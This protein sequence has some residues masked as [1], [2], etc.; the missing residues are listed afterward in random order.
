MHCSE[1]AVLDKG[2]GATKQSGSVENTRNVEISTTFEYARV[3]AMHRS[4]ELH[5]QVWCVV[6]LWF[7]IL[8]LGGCGSTQPEAATPSTQPESA[9]PVRTGGDETPT[10]G[11][12][13]A[14][15][16]LTADYEP[17]F[18]PTECPFDVPS[19]GS[20]AC[21]FLVVPEDRSRADSPDVRLAVAVIQ[22]MA[23]DPEP[24][25]I[26]FLE[27]GPGGRALS[28]FQPWLDSGL[29]QNR[30]LVLFDQRGTG[31]SQPDLNC[32][33]ANWYG[34]ADEG[35]AGGAPDSYVDAM[36]ACRD[37]LV[38]EGVDLAAYTSA[39]SAADTHDLIRVLDYDEV[40]LLGISYGTRLALTMMRDFPQHIRSVVLDS[41]YPPNVNDYVE[42]AAIANRALEQLFDACAAD[43]ACDT[44]YPNLETT[45]STQVERLNATPVETTTIDPE[46]GEEYAIILD[47]N[48]LFDTVDQ[49]L[50]V[51]EIIPLLPRMI[52]ETASNDYDLLVELSQWLLWVPI[53]ELDSD[54]EGMFYSVMCYEELPFIRYEEVVDS[55]KAGDLVG[56]YILSN[57][58]MDRT[59]CATWGGDSVDPIENEPVQSDIPTLILAGAYDPRTPPEWGR[60]ASETLENSFF[61]EFPGSGHGVSL[62]GGCPTEIT[63][64][65]LNN[66][67]S[68][69]DT[70]CLEEMT[71]PQFE[72][73]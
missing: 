64:L 71:G 1:E 25:P 13:A 32:P 46:T 50:Y 28:G 72:V 14:E 11:E 53:D 54:S 15:E 18:E 40:N 65:F 63:Q 36:L 55:V 48:E 62:D 24:D 2:R 29:T 66:P 4:C 17:R 68:E 16:W 31:F 49:G 38:S 51:T 61:Y 47:G 56:D 37:R 67:T 26:I 6:V 23:E 3:E 52:A 58:E 41:P 22:S 73:P 59:I 27:G 69:P 34:E 10:S 39:A 8:L 42:Q 33:E 45:F 43:S 57:F 30:D 12:S 9:T 19:A 20:F 7:G 44:A 21:G 35:T 5:Y 70:G 60:V